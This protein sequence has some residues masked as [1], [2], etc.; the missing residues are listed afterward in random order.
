MIGIHMR[1]RTYLPL[2]CCL[3][4]ALTGPVKALDL[5]ERYPT[6][7]TA[8]DV[9]PDQAR[10]WQFVDCRPGAVALCG[11]ILFVAMK[12]WDPVLKKGGHPAKS[13]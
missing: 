7:L 5:L 13:F 11:L 6:Q 1:M 12:A 8:G 2:F 4:G 9:S 10:E 3:F